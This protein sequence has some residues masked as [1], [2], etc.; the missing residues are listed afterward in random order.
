MERKKELDGRGFGLGW[1]EKR[2]EIAFTKV[3]RV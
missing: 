2:R 1:I 3:S